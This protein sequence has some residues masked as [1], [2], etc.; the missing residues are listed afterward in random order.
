MKQEREAS[1]FGVFS[2]HRPFL[3]LIIIC[4]PVLAGA[5]KPKHSFTGT[6]NTT[7]GL[8]VLKQDGQAVK[9]HYDFEDAEAKIEGTVEKNKL[10]F[11]YEEPTGVKGE[12]WFE[13]AVDG[14]SFKG[15]WRE[16]EQSWQKWEGKRTRDVQIGYAGLWE[17]SFGRMRLLET[18]KKVEG[19]YSYSSASTLSGTVQNKKLTFTYKEPKD[20]GEGWFE[21]AADGQSFQGQWRVKGNE[22]WAEWKGRRIQP[23]PGLVWLV[24]IEANWES[25]LAEQEYAFGT[26]LRAF[27]ARSE[28]VKVRHRFFNDAAGLKKWCREVAFL[29]E[30]VVV[31]LATHGSP[32]GASVDGQN[33]DG[34]SLVESL[35]YAG[36]VKLLHFSACEMMK[37]RLAAEM[38]A[39]LKKYASF[40]ISGYTTCVDWAASAILEF[41]YFDMILCRDI[42]PQKAADQVYKLLAFAGDKEVPGS[43]LPAMGF[44]LLMPK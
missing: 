19:I 37:D 20:E 17:T 41:T 29:A 34:V 23:K 25:N 7:F 44:K 5:D 4:L 28:K 3:A 31:S 22:A 10:T 36:N 35:R 15:Q 24:V 18:D 1:H 9:G 8:M 39:A 21:L 30:P 2:M 13:L 6:W 38:L 32:K 11:T 33:V 40:P 12:G 27:F 42:A 26:M 16:P 14:S 43:V